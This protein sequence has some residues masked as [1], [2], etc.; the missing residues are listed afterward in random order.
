MKNVF[1][2]TLCFFEFFLKTLLLGD[3]RMGTRH[4]EGFAVFIPNC[5]SPGENP[6][7]G[8]V[9]MPHPEFDLIASGFT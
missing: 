8:S 1:E 3:I 6:A 4:A 2:L 7:I 9:C 5:L